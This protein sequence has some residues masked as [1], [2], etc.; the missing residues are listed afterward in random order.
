MKDKTYWVKL[1]IVSAVRAKS[2]AKAGMRAADIATR[3]GMFVY[4]IVE[5]H[6]AEDMLP[7]VPSCIG[8][9][10]DLE[11]STDEEVESS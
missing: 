9:R 5:S 6:D 7:R 2:A 4:E 1:T 3:Q 11:A 10:V 8:S